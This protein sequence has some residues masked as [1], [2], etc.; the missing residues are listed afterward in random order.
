MTDDVIL[1]DAQGLVDAAERVAEAH[2]DF[3][4][5]ESA[6]EVLVTLLQEKAEEAQAPDTLA[7][8]LRESTRDWGTTS[9]ESP[10]SVEEKQAELREQMGL[11]SEE[12]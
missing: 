8:A 2:D 1:A 9:H 4:G 5:D 7:E 10:D 3:S 11:D 6:S 12:E